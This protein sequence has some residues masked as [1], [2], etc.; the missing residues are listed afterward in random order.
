MRTARSSSRPGVSPPAPP[1][2]WPGTPLDQ[3]HPEPGTPWDQAPPPDQAAP[4]TRHTLPGADTPRARHPPW[5][6]THACKH[7]TLPQTSF[8]G[9]N[10]WL[11]AMVLI[12]VL[13]MRNKLTVFF[14]LVLWL[15]LHPYGQ[16]TP[17]IFKAWTIIWTIRIIMGCIVPNECIHTCNSPNYCDYNAT[18]SYVNSSRNSSRLKNHRYEWTLGTVQHIIMWIVHA[19]V[20]V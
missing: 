5:G 16:I 18:H 20:H 12:L 6:Q 14:I 15:V 3:V 7:I 9:G 19:I 11:I 1:I 17:V 10:E 13:E 2:L 4:R 8:A